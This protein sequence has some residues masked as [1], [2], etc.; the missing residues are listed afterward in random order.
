MSFAPRSRIVF[1]SL[2]AGVVL[3]GG[4]AEA[5]FPLSPAMWQENIS[6]SSDSAPTTFQGADDFAPESHIE[7]L[8]GISFNATGSIQFGSGVAPEG[9]AEVTWDVSE[10]T[11][12]L[13]LSSILN[14]D[15]QARVIETSTPPVA[16]TE[17]P[18]HLV[19][20]GSGVAD[21]VFGSRATSQFVFRAIGTEVLV[22]ANLDVDGNSES[23][24]PSSDTFSIDETVMVPVDAVILVSMTA[25]ASMGSVGVPPGST[26]KATGMVDPVIEIVDEIIPGTSDSYRDYFAVE[27]S[28]GYGAQTPVQRVTFGEIKSR[29]SGQR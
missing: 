18:V 25:T 21:E 28:D 22:S 5:Q 23:P 11:T 7:E 3:L 19:A 24:N 9:T 10:L 17:V 2:F 26:G 4:R 1:L 8:S 12:P 27:F 16:V 14:I 29:F 15:F 13:N 20:N 6:L